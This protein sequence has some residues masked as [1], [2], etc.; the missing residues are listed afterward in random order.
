MA[1]PFVSVDGF[2]PNS[3]V[4]W[5]AMPRRESALVEAVA[6]SVGERKIWSIL[7]GGVPI[8]SGAT[9]VFDLIYVVGA[10]KFTG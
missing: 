6:A 8:P 1:F 7:E 3:L 10:P 2:N 9:A 5:S 4:G